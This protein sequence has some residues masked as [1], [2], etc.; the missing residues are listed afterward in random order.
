M[1]LS[2]HSWLIYSEPKNVSELH[3]RSIDGF[4][5][6]KLIVYLTLDSNSEFLTDRS[7]SMLHFIPAYDPT[8]TLSFSWLSPDYQAPL[9]CSSNQFW[10]LDEC[11]SAKHLIDFVNLNSD[12]SIPLPVLNTAESSS[13]A[14]EVWVYVTNS[15][16]NMWIFHHSQLTALG[17]TLE[18]KLI[19]ESPF[20]QTDNASHP[21][22]ISSNEWHHVGVSILGS[23][24]TILL[25]EE[26]SEVASTLAAS[27]SGKLSLGSHP[28]YD[29][30]F[31][32]TMA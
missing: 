3:F 32:G 17:V 4:S 21:S 13:I 7:I 19:A 10:V 26:S 14:Y 12:L 5:N 27:V 20:L 1:E 31:Q 18:S 11:R 2:S 22:P 6:P 9:L 24:I 15:T 23:S 8:T 16:S 25:N 29:G 30:R 28:D